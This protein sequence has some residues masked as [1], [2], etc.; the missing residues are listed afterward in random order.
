MGGTARTAEQI[1]GGV[2]TGIQQIL[3]LAVGQGIA[4]E[5]AILTEYVVEL[6]TLFRGAF[7]ALAELVHAVAISVGVMSSLH[8]ATALVF[9]FVQTV[10]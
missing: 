8:T 7:R 1:G 10:M 2:Q 5:P 3:I 4:K 9:L 6:A